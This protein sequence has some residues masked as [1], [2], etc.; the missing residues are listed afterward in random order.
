M[1]VSQPTNLIVTLMA[2][3]AQVYIF[4]TVKSTEMRVGLALFAVYQIWQ[5]FRKSDTSAAAAAEN[6]AIS[7][8]Q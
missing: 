5:K 2:F 3:V 4:Y 7:K 6:D 1:P 8:Q